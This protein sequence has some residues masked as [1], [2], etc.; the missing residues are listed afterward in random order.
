L[1]NYGVVRLGGAAARTPGMTEWLRTKGCKVPD[2]NDGERLID[3]AERE[4]LPE[5]RR[6]IAAGTDINYRGES[7]WTPLFKAGTWG[8]PKAVKLLL[9]NHADPNQLRYKHYSTL[10]LAKTAEIAEML[11][12]A[13][14]KLRPGDIRYG[15]TFNSVELAQW[16][17]DHGVP[18]NEVDKSGATLLFSARRPEIAELL[19]ARGVDVKAKD[20]SGTTALESV[21]QRVEEPAEIVAV[22]LKHGADPNA[23]SPGSGYTPLRFARDGATVDVLVA[24]GANLQAKD[25]RGDGVMA[26]TAP[27]WARSKPSRMD[28]L[29]RHGLKL[30]AEKAGEML[31]DAIVF[32]HDL[33]TVQTLLARGID[34]DIGDRSRGW[35][36]SPISA[37]LCDGSFKIADALRAAGAKD[38]G[39]LSDA[40]ARGDVAR[41]T[42]LLDGG[43]KVN[44]RSSFGYTPLH[45][46]VMQAQAGA[47]RLLLERGANVSYFDNVG[48]TP[49]AY[50]FSALGDIEYRK[51]SQVRRLD[52]SAAK[53]AFDEIVALIQE[54]KVD[55]NFR[56]EDGET[57]LMC[58]AKSGNLAALVEGTDVNLQRPDGMTALMLAIVTQPKGDALKAE[59]T[60]RE[61]DKEGKRGPEFSRRG[62]VVNTLIKK[63]ADLSLRNK[64]GKTALDLARENGSP[65][66]L[67]LMEKATEKA[68]EKK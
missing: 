4:D 5:M 64:A 34:P 56:N 3:A 66:I 1:L 6:L 53:K 25:N 67:E 43:A 61:I 44:E 15:L 45:F 27:G 36:R 37:A 33:A 8:S 30:E 28:A 35:P 26:V 18:I 51:S 22:L 63:G 65:E 29:I 47:V 60:V 24:A 48:L 13:G 17:L 9:E 57:A 54:R 40:A 31:A 39:L 12:A 11:F 50:A 32:Y 46:A 21:M 23:R 14:V 58:S 62:D 16:F 2:Y 19:I 52:L 55:R 68:P 59:G 20:Q 38:V 42:V 10:E 49:L 7:D 41:M